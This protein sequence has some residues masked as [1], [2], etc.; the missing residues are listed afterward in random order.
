LKAR[1][2]SALLNTDSSWRSNGMPSTVS[3]TPTRRTNGE[4]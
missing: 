3:D 1:I 2:V 4:S